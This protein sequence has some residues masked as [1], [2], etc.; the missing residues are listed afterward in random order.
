MNKYRVAV[1]AGGTGGHVFPALAVV[2][3]LRQHNVDII[4]LGTRRGLEAQLVP[5]AGIPIEWI[6]VRGLRGTGWKRWLLAPLMLGHAFWQALKVLRRYKPDLVLGMGG[7][8]S[9]PAGIAARCLGIHLVV[10]EQNAIPGTTNRYLARLATRVLQ[11]FPDSFPA[12]RNALTVGNPVRSQILALPSPIQRFSESER[13]S[14][15]PRLLVLG[16]SQGAQILNRIVP[17]ALALF[18]E[19]ERPKVWH[20]TGEAMYDDTLAAYHEAGIEVQLNPFIDDMAQAYGWADLV[21][22]RAGALTVSELIGSGIGAILIPFPFAIDDHQT[23]NARF[24]ERNGAALILP[25]TDLTAADLAKH[26]K[27]LLSD[28]AQLLAMAEAA[29]S[30]AQTRATEKVTEVCL[31]QLSA[32]KS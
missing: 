3:G 13:E 31:Q 32:L 23:A 1:L 21:L 12:S 24:M 5:A 7:F 4:W 16:G 10:H 28:R 11:A 19:F 30:L 29:H 20:Q 27:K 26:L 9:G 2:D 18:A 6:N 22:C 15:A 17:K 14:A 8:V 25:Q